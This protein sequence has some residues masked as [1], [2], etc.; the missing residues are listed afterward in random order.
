MKKIIKG[1]EKYK[2][3]SIIAGTATGTREGY[4]GRC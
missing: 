3:F 1:V 4:G 2:D